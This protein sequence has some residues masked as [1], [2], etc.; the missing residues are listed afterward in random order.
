MFPLSLKGVERFKYTVSK[1]LHVLGFP[2][3]AREIF[4]FRTE[5]RISRL[6]HFSK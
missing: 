4:L 3:P 2:V 1:I 5:A 6:A